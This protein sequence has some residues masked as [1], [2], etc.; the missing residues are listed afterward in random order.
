M[1]G[2]SCGSFAA[3]LCI[4][5]CQWSTSW[6]FVPIF[7]SWLI[8]R[9]TT[10][11]GRRVRKPACHA[12]CSIATSFVRFVANGVFPEHGHEL[13]EEFIVLEGEFADENRRYPVGTYIRHPPGSRHTPFS[14][15]GCLIWVKLRQFDEKDLTQLVTALDST[16]PK[17][18]WRAR[19]LHR[20]RGE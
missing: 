16:I 18:G 20:F 6:K 7:R 5:T 9:Q 12:L 11:V 3:S 15:P 14:D 4:Y 8:S 1:L 2:V 17:Q 19:E 10:G 13:G